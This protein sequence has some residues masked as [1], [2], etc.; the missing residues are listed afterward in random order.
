[1]SRLE[2]IIKYWRR[3]SL[4]WH[5]IEALGLTAVIGLIDY[6]TGNEVTVDPFYSIPI[7]LTVWFG[8]KNLAIVISVCC[9]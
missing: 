5:F 1:M 7:L 4:T 3:R 2:F 8:N 6:F 9:A